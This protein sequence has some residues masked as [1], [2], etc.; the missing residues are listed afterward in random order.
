MIKRESSNLS[1][2]HFYSFS[3]H[4]ALDWFKVSIDRQ[5]YF[6]DGGSVDIKEF[7]TEW[8]THVWVSY[9]LVTVNYE[10]SEDEALYVISKDMYEYESYIMG[11]CRHV[12]YLFNEMRISPD[13]PLGLRLV[14]GVMFVY[15][16]VL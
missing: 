14:E 13:T 6:L 5:E 7:F 1:N 16:E 11:E 10:V 12:R 3:V 2:R 9:G 15:L 8:L 4:D